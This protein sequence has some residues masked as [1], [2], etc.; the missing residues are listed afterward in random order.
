MLRTLQAHRLRFALGAAALLFSFSKP[1]L[2]ET[3]VSPRWDVWVVDEA[4]QPVV[5]INVTLVREDYSCESVDHSETLFTDAQGHVQF[6]PRYMK[7]SPFKCAYYTAGALMPFTHHE[8]GRH[9]SVTAGDPNGAL[10]GKAVDKDGHPIDWTGS[11]DQL[12]T[13]MIVRRRKPTK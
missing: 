1:T 8:H 2:A 9:A 6:R 3:T 10:F 11:P 12:K 4:G 5:G 13:H 7:W